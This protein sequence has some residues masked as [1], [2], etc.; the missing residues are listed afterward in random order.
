MSILSH[1]KSPENQNQFIKL[2]KS[3]VTKIYMDTCLES[4]AIKV[5]ESIS[6]QP[7][8]MIHNNIYK[9]YKDY[10]LD[11]SVYNPTIIGR[12]YLDKIE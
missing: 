3:Q 11:L 9:N 1:C 4:S 8:Y 12:E 6:R 2:C 7:A 5:I 10:S